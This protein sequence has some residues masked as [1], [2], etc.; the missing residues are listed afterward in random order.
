VARL[1]QKQ[2][3]EYKVSYIHLRTANL[4]EVNFVV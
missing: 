3:S 4:Q 1:I 2:K